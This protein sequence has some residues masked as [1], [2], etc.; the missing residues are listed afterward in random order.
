MKDDGDPWLEE[1]W[2]E[3]GAEDP[4]LVAQEQL[5]EC[6]DAEQL[7]RYRV[8]REGLLWRPLGV[9]ESACLNRAR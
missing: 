1:L 8:R 7:E 3:R 4:R 5:H 2:R 6:F 9:Q